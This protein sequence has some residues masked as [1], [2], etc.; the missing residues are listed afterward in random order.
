ARPGTG[1]AQ[2][3][4]LRA[5][6]GVELRPGQRGPAGNV[7]DRGLVGRGPRRPG[8]QIGQVVRGPVLRAAAVAVHGSPKGLPPSW[9]ASPA[10][11]ARTGWRGGPDARRSGLPRRH[12]GAVTLTARSRPLTG[13]RAR[14]AVVRAPPHLAARMLRR[15]S[16]LNG[17]PTRSSRS[18]PEGV[19]CC[20]SP[21]AHRGP[22]RRTPVRCADARH[23]VPKTDVPTT[24]PVPGP[25]GSH[26]PSRATASA[27][28]HRD[29][30][31]PG[32]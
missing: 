15:Y 12:A 31:Y 27:A 24:D 17:R 4:G 26:D 28:P 2:A 14:R 25:A 32:G 5:D 8:D 13:T 7:D 16:Q 29:H 3:G 1:L 21:P 19:A 6:R 11:L 30:P 18:S 10:S 20:L 22:T 23:G 9:M